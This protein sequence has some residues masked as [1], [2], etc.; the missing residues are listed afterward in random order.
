MKGSGGNLA[1]NAPLP[2]PTNA[3]G[4]MQCKYCTIHCNSFQAMS[5]DIRKGSI[6]MIIRQLK[7]D[8]FESLH[9]SLIRKA[10]SEPL[11]ASYTV[12]M[13]INGAE[14]A[15]KVQPEPHNKIAILQAL[16]IYREEHGPNFELNTQGNVLSS[17][18]E[19]LI[20]Q[21]VA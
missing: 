14:Y 5:G 10:R 18:L 8:Q 11:E 21:G 12:T 7:K 13:T 6:K 20:Y 9:S 19:L 2:Q 16:R 15:V 17:L 1:S 4:Q 3:Q